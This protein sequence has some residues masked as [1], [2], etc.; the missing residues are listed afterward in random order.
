[1][2]YG[3]SGNGIVHIIHETP[4]NGACGYWYAACGKWIRPT[5]ILEDA[6]EG[7]RL[8]LHCQKREEPR[9]KD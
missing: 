2:Q 7:A 5:E 8:C 1:M 6:P 4:S 9:W 3:I